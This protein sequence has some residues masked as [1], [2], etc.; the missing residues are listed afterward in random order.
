MRYT[1]QCVLLLLASVSLA[2]SARSLSPHA[3][4]APASDIGSLLRAFDADVQR[5]FLDNSRGFGL[6]RVMTRIPGRHG[7]IT[8]HFTPENDSEQRVVRGFDEAGV[9]LVLYVGGPSLLMR[10]SSSGTTPAAVATDAPQSQALTQV[11]LMFPVNAPWRPR[12]ALAGPVSVI[13]RS[14]SEPPGAA[15]LHQ[16]ARRSFVAVR[17]EDVVQFRQ[18]E[19]EL[20]V[21]PVRAAKASCLECHNSNPER[22]RRPDGALTS[23]KAGDVLGIVVYATRS[24]E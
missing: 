15:G 23:Y 9:D 16:Q 20:S 5:R 21:R 17:S 7:S 3:A 8:A 14:G 11:N 10:S 2:G 13:Q 1:A 24:R 12:P 22:P 19:W 4:P 6:S 18:D